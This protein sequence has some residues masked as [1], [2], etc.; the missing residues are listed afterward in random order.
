[1]RLGLTYDLQTDASDERQAEFDPP[2]V[3]A[4]LR[5][6]LEALG[7][8]VAPL[9]GA[10]DLL[11][12]PGRLKGV[13]LVFNIAEGDEGRCREAWVPVLLDLFEVPYVGSDALALALGLD[14]AAVKRLAVAAGLRTPPWM[15]L[16]HPGSVPQTVPLRFPL[17]VKPRY[18]GSGRGIDAGAVVRTP[19]ELSARAAW[20][21]ARCRQP[22]LVEEFIAHGELTICVIGNDPPTAHPV[23]QR[24]VDAATRLSCH[25]LGSTPARW[26]SPLVLDAALE[27]EARRM[28]L[29]IFQLLGC[30]DMARVDLRV[31]ERGTVYLLEINPLP[32]FD[33]E[34]SFGESLR[35]RAMNAHLAQHGDAYLQ[36]GMEEAR[37]RVRGGLREF[38]HQSGTASAAPEG[39]EPRRISLEEL[40]RFGQDARVL[41]VIGRRALEKGLPRCA[42]PNGMSVEDLKA[43]RAGEPPPN[44][45]LVA[46]R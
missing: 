16:E 46:R 9:G 1:M 24:P 32:S 21:F 28:A 38:L 20:L 37:E 8:A 17:I 18:E 6:A 26:E 27:A 3:I 23:I 25:V 31:D 39:G 11:R 7:H 5:A 30:R 41:A 43:I 10:R 29:G 19:A 4:A 22:M 45:K 2:A 36:H 35:R 33:P 12:D 14:K 13:E 44:G 34:G 15:V 42:F 40:Q